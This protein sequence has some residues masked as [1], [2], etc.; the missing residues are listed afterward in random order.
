MTTF[1]RGY[2]PDFPF[3]GPGEIYGF[4]HEILTAKCFDDGIFMGRFARMRSED[5]LSTR[6]GQ[7]AIAAPIG[8]AQNGLPIPIATGVLASIDPEEDDPVI[9]GII[10]KRLTSPVEEGVALTSARISL[11]EYSY[12]GV[13]AVEV[14]DGATPNFNDRVYV[15]R[16]PEN[17]GMATEEPTFSYATTNPAAT[18]TGDNI[19]TASTFL[20]KIT[21]G[22]WYIR[23]TP[24]P[25]A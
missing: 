19:S 15:D 16:N 9:A 20:G 3:A 21:D 8:S 22:V 1:N 17:L 14:P 13:I 4:V 11:V 23:L 2:A 10:T 12:S 6:A 24:S 18:K 5:K 25:N 7:N